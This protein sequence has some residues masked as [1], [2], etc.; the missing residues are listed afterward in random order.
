MLMIIPMTT[1]NTI[2][3]TRMITAMSTVTVTA[4]RMIMA[5]GGGRFVN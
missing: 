3:G 2:T 5:E 4:T 1:M